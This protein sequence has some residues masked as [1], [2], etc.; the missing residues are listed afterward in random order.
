MIRKYIDQDETRVIDIW[1]YT[2]SSAHSFLDAVFV[3]KVKKDMKDIYL[4]NAETWVFEKNNAVIGFISMIENEIAGLFVYPDQ[5]SKGIGTLLVNFV[6][7]LHKELEVEVFKNNKIGRSFYDKYG[8]KMMKEYF[9]EES[10][11]ILLRM[12]FSS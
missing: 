11:Q 1:Y 12:K 3:E 4:P 7:D 8:F 5:Q 9:H 2:S 6:G 10:K